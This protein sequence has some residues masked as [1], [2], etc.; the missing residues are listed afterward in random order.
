MGFKDY[1]TKGTRQGKI[2]NALLIISFVLAAYLGSYL[3]S[4]PPLI[5]IDFPCFAEVENG[6][7]SERYYEADVEKYAWLFVTYHPAFSN[8]AGCRDNYLDNGATIKMGE[9]SVKVEGQN[10][11]VDG[12]TLKP[13]DEWKNKKVEFDIA[14]PW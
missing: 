3:L 13:G 10:L 5:G 12:K 8:G 4:L 7:I 14:N 6:Y 2:K 9:Y 1:F 11:I